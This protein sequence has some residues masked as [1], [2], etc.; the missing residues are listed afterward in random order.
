MNSNYSKTNYFFGL[1]F[2]VY[3]FTY[4]IL[5]LSSFAVFFVFY[6]FKYIDPN[7]SKIY[8]NNGMSHQTNSILVFSVDGTL[9]SFNDAKARKFCEYGTI[10]D[11]YDFYQKPV[12]INYKFAPIYKTESSVFEALLLSLVFFSFG[13]IVI[14]TIFRNKIKN[15]SL[16]KRFLNV[17]YFLIK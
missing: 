5:V 13:A 9:D 11:Y 2:F 12:Q 16:G 1:S 3:I 7:E 6:P 15:F 8:C 4:I 17:I 10:M 14:E